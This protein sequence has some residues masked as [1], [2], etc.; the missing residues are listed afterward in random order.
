MK[1]EA[2]GYLYCIPYMG[3]RWI[4]AKKKYGE[5]ISDI[6]DVDEEDLFGRSISNLFD[7]LEGKKVRIIVE[8]IED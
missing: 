4:I 1:R 7:G 6:D 8:V 3:D 2:E 5:F